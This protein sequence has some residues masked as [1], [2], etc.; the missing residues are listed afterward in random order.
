[1]I[2]EPLDSAAIWIVLLINTAIGFF[3]ELRAR[4]A[5]EALLALDVP[6]A[7]V[8]RDGRVTDIEAAGLVPG[9]VVQVEA[10]QAIPA[11]ARV[12]R[13]TGLRVVE[14]ALTGESVPATKSEDLVLAESEPLPARDNMLYKG[15]AVSEGSAQAIVTATGMATEV[16]RIGELVSTI[17]EEKT[18]LE[19]RLDALGG[20][21]VYVTLALAALVTAIGAVQG[22]PLG[23]MIETG[24]ALAI[25]A[26][27]EGLPAVAT[28]AL[29]VGLRRMAR[30]RA[31][32]RRLGAVEALGSSTVICTDKTGT[33]TAGQMT[34]R[35][36]WAGGREVAITGSGYTREGTF[37]DAGE[38]IEPLEDPVISQALRIAVL[39]NRAEVDLDRDDPLTVGDPTEVALLIAGQKAG[40]GRE[41]L[42]EERPQVGELPFSAE[43]M[44]MASF[45]REA[46]RQ[47]AYVKGAPEQILASSTEELTPEGDVPLDDERRRT[48]LAANQ[49]LATRGLR[50]LGLAYQSQGDAAGSGAGAVDHLSFVAFIGLIDPPAEGVEE[51]IERFREAG[52][53]TVML[54]GDQRATA[55]AIGRDLGVLVGGEEVVDGA[56]LH[57]LPV[58]QPGNRFERVGAFSRVSPEDKLTIVSGFQADGEIVAMLGDG[59]NDA[60]ALKKADVGVAMGVR[61]TDAAKEAAAVVLQ[62]D[63]FSTLA[64]AVE[65]G[66]I[67][68]DNIRKFVFYLFGCNFAEVLVLFT[69]SLAALP[70]PAAPLANPVAEHRHG[71]VPGAFPRVRAGRT[72]A[73]AKA[74]RRSSQGHPVSE[75]HPRGELLRESHRDQHPD[76]VHVGSTIFSGRPRARRDRGFSDARARSDLPPRER[77]QPRAGR[78]AGAGVPQPAGGRGGAALAFA[79]VARRLLRASRG[80]PG[81]V[82]AACP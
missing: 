27:P 58:R 61:G 59:I 66:R 28:I 60:A 42:L 10:G 13:A 75:L 82:G 50:V 52:I 63:R 4:R 7:T 45:H 76:R 19:R 51:T 53:R 15:T 43:R 70:L 39:A 44:L 68:Y 3:T 79:H 81:L 67:I 71:H 73:H 55:E 31:L 48:L 22:K 21:L 16:G 36:L 9:D 33:L 30:R 38:E 1:M 47:I 54:T 40:L 20:R 2:G 29:A 11:D 17:P 26:V 23:L 6:R 77:T 35:L 69:S 80:R 74:S 64:T 8:I 5:M 62:D 57:R 24:I 34:A 18:P 14:A 72:R 32:I 41:A 78:G 37:I 12:F 49:D 25:A 65:A 56:E 46:D